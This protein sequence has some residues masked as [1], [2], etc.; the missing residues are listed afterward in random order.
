MAY[1]N[2]AHKKAIA[3]LLKDIVPK[4]WKYSLSVQNHSGI[5]FTIKKADTDLISECINK[6]SERPDSIELNIYFLEN[7]YTGKTLETMQA[8]LKVLNLDNWNRS[9]IQTDHFDIGHYVYMYIG[10]WNKPFI[11]TEK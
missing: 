5:V 2:Q 1:M 8:I 4:S 6:R 9:D 10:R 11:V 3:L 7:S